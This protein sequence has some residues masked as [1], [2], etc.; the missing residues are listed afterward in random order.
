MPLFL[1]VLLLAVAAGGEDSWGLDE[2]LYSSS[3]LPRVVGG[4]NTT[5]SSS[6][7]NNVGR[8][9]FCK[10]VS[11]IFLFRFFFPFFFFFL[12]PLLEPHV[13]PS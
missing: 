10:Q 1:L 13:R 5:N 3:Q 9:S 2:A 4:G 12:F 8:C 11:F 7:P 6:V